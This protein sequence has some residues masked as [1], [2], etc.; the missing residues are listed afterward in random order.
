MKSDFFWHPSIQRFGEG[1]GAG[2]A[3]SGGTA[4]A[5][6]EQTGEMDFGAFLAQNPKYKGEHERIVK[7]ATEK[8]IK[9]RFRKNEADRASLAPLISGLATQYGI[10]PDEGGNYDYKRIADAYMGDD[11]RYE[12]EAMETGKSVAEIKQA[13]AD[14]ADLQR[15][16]AEEAQRKQDES[17]M[18]TIQRV[19][20]EIQ[21]ASRS[22]PG[23]DF[24]AELN[25]NPKFRNAVYS[26]TFTVEEA[27]RAL[28]GK[29]LE[30]NAMQYTAAK[31]KEDVA[32][33]VAAG[34]ARPRE[35]A[36]G[37]NPASSV[38]FDPRNLTKEQ[39]KEIRR[40]TLMGNPPSF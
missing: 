15:Y 5:A 27:Y 23:V 16:R 19:D 25:S 35:G 29:E 26:G 7:E 38:S 39:R 33:S 11:S 37:G 4:P 2:G 22:I 21:E 28:H 18:A 10:K 17:R 8:A 40:Q 34:Q 1:D 3:D 13:K 32:A 9:G 31:T 24:M 30:K 20:K 6:G 12:A 14:A 36:A